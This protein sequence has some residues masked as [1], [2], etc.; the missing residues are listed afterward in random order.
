LLK[1]H[2]APIELKVLPFMMSRL[3]PLGAAT[4][5]ASL[6]VPAQAGTEGWADASDVARN[7]LVAAAL[8]AP[9]VQDDWNG[10]LQA[11]GSIAVAYGATYGLK[12]TFPTWR[13]DRSDRKSFPSSHTSTSFAAAATIQNRHGWKAGLPAHAAAIFVGVARVKADKHRWYDAVAGAAIGS[14]A[15]FLITNKRNPN[16]QVFPW[17]DTK[18]GGVGLAMRF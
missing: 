6:S 16:V 11:G 18:G 4:A 14:A 8:L 10:V 3:V 13:P 9:A 5:L 7:A 15:G 17:G 1:L 2:H 12:E